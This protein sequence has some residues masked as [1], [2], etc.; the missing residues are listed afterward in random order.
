MLSALHQLSSYEPGRPSFCEPGVAS[1]L[2]ARLKH[3]DGKIR[4]LAAVTLQNLARLS[5][6][7]TELAEPA[8]VDTLVATLALRE[9][10]CSLPV[11]SVLQYLAS[12]ETCRLLLGDR[13]VL[14]PITQV[15]PHPSYEERAILLVVNLA[16]S[17][18]LENTVV[19]SGV[20]ATLIAKLKNSVSDDLQSLRM[21]RWFS[22]PVKD[23]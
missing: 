4:H 10:S 12:S 8:L 20:L 15:L 16:S 19:E 3:D 6:F 2:V 22:Q 11:L 1:R 17:R 18:Q 7:R 9:K 5:A 13:G 14:Q 23:S 21:V